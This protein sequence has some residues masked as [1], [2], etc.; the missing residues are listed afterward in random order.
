ADLRLPVRWILPHH[1]IRRLAIHEYQRVC[2]ADDALFHAAP[3]TTLP[4]RRSGV[5]WVR[6]VDPWIAEMR[7]PR[8]I[9]KAL[10]FQTDQMIRPGLRERCDHVEPSLGRETPSR[11]RRCVY[12][13]P[14]FVRH[15]LEARNQAPETAQEE[16]FFGRMH[17]HQ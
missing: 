9:E 13:H 10:E 1:S 11:A 5:R 8:Q 4:F 6:A 7:D 3:E 14:L 16:T 12:P 17:R 15:H 2:V